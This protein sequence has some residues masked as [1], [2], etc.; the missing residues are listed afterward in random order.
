MAKKS[1]STLVIK[2]ERAAYKLLLPTIII[3]LLVAVYPFV[4]VFYT[5]TTDR[6]FAGTSETEFIGLENYKQLL[7]FTIQ[8]VPPKTDDEGNIVTDSE[9]GKTE[10]EH[11]IEVLPM[12]PVRYKAAYQFNLFGNQYVIGA[13]SPD[14]VRAIV[15]TLIFSAVAVFLETLFG[16]IIALVVDS[17]FKGRGLMRALMLIPWAVITVVSARMWEW[18]LHPSRMGFFNTILSNMGLGDGNIAFLATDSLQLPSVI[19]ADVWKTTPFM[20]LL[21]LAGLQMIPQELYEAAWV[22][23]AN[24]FR[25]FTTITLPLLKPIIAVALVFRTLDSL[26]VF[27]PF[28]VMLGSSKYSMATFNY[29]QLIGN[30]EM[31]LASAIGVIIFILISLFAYFYI[32]MLGV[33]TE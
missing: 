27:G 3:L 22:D 23:G 9:T 10:Y 7:G 8:E 17:K 14:F 5:S 11:P 2:E 13:R 12:R 28:Q 31:G 30:R 15:N 29:Y 1:K 16:L 25:Q 20:A 6:V 32:K 24:R 4:Q 18:M 26:R 33:D 19:A 21:I